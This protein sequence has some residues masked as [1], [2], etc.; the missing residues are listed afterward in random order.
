[1]N[2]VHATAYD[3]ISYPGYPFGETHPG[4]L[5]TLGLL[6]GMTPAPLQSCRVLELGCGDGANIIPV[7]FQWPDSQFV[8]LDL[9]AQA[10]THAL[11]GVQ[12]QDPVVGRRIRGELLLRA[13]AGPVALDDACTQRRSARPGVVGGV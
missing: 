6:F 5:A 4:H 3:H 13:I 1:M 12:A 10:F 9:S 7:A 2:D 8:G 11:V